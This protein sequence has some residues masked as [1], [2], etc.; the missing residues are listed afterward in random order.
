MSTYIFRFANQN[1][2]IAHLFHFAKLKINETKCI[3]S[4]VEENGFVVVTADG[5]Y[6]RA[7]FD[8]A[9]GGECTKIDE[10][11]IQVEK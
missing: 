5:K 2:I 8:P 7:K 10:Q 3:A 11:V 4:F 1:A 6:Y 9:K